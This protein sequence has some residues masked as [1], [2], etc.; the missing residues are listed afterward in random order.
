M[1]IG[2]ICPLDGENLHL[3]SS[4]KFVSCR[5]NH[6]FD[7]AKQGYL[8]LLP[9]QQK[10]SKQPGDDKTMVEARCRFL[11]SGV[12][13]QIA[14]AAINLTKQNHTDVS[15]LDAGCGEGYY[16]R[17]F[18]LQLPQAK[19]AGLD[20]SKDAVL[21][22]ARQNRQHNQ[23]VQY[24]VASN[25]NIPVADN[26]LS[27]IL[28]MFG[29]PVY[30]EFAK[31]LQTHGLLI[32]VDSGEKHLLELRQAIYPELKAFTPINRD[33]A[34]AAGFKLINTESVQYAYCLNQQQISDL[35]LMTPHG[36]KGN[37][38]KITAL[39]QQSEFTLGIDAQISVW[40]QENR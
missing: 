1:S 31:K 25:K 38:D 35:L 19:L 32:C 30:A 24:L 23:Q 29:F 17:Q 14:Q 5:N 20:I 22:A 12:Y 10:R 16:L 3:H 27:H 26:S 33:S 37:T 6:H 28:C 8:N 21:S 39:K 4:H 7:F 34:I 11:N 9:V 36:H 40:Q 13:Q 15:L 2:L 18:A